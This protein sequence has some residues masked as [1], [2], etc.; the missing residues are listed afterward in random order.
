MRST[1]IKIIKYA[2][3]FLV[4]IVLLMIFL[5]RTYNVPSLQAKQGIQFWELSTGSKIGYTHIAAKG[6]KKPYPVI[7]LHGGP[8]GHVSD[9]YIQT[10]TPLA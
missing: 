9:K 6:Q 1:I 3:L 8:G 4:V 7:Y 10:L 2:I 5:P